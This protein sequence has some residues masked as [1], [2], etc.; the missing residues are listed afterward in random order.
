MKKVA[1]VINT[2]W[3]IYNFRMNLLKALQA[4]GMQIYAI[5]PPDAYSKK[6]EE[7]GFTY[8]PVKMQ[9]TGANPFNELGVIHELYHAYRKIK[10]DVVLHY[11]IK[12][13]L[14][15]SV[16]ARMLG[17]PCINNVSGLGTAFL[18]DNL[19]AK[20]ARK[21]YRFA[22]RTPEKVF[23]QNS[24]DRRIFVKFGLVKPEVTEVIPGSG[25]DTARF[26]PNGHYKQEEFV[27]LMISRVLYDK[28]VVEYA[29]AIRQLKNKGIHAKFQLLGATDPGHRSGIPIS[30]LKSWQNEGLIDYIGTADDVLPVIRKADCV[31]LPSYREG[32]PRTLLEAA[33]VGKPLIATD[34]PGC[35]NV[36]VHGK[37]GYLCKAKDSQDLASK[38]FS[39]YNLPNSERLDMGKESRLIAEQK[40]DEKF[41]IDRYRDTIK[42]LI[43]SSIQE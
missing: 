38:L 2:S 34:V 26:S 4:D 21:L 6:L 10:P 41:V 35:N 23:F 40:F 17:I 43:S 22:F 24:D 30:E 18:Q 20:I 29:E 32:T 16:V 1:I 9:S 31:V 3:N 42:E 19:V 13:N 39:M 14:Y 36:V 15:G 37:N 27:F 11:T 7:A 25:V 33:S 28:G 12:P 5:A 8:V